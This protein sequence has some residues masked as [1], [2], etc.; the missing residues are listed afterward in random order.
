MEAEGQSKEDI[1]N[2]F[3]LARFAPIYQSVLAITN[4]NNFITNAY[5]SKRISELPQDYQNGVKMVNGLVSK[6]PG[7]I[8]KLK[9]TSKSIK[10]S[11]EKEIVQAVIN[12]LDG[13]R[14]ISTRISL[15]KKHISEVN[16]YTNFIIKCTE[17]FRKYNDYLINDR[18]LR[19]EVPQQELLDISMHINDR[20]Q[21]ILVLIDEL[22]QINSKNNEHNLYS[23]DC[24][25]QFGDILD[26]IF[27]YVTLIIKKYE[28]VRY[29]IDELKLRVYGFKP[30]TSSIIDRISIDDDHK[31]HIAEK[32]KNVEFLLRKQ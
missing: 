4:L 19:I 8:Q 25:A 28:E 27:A 2:E 32:L 22:Y 17:G 30:P 3:E 7:S 12:R 16:E 10:E 14:Y 1:E 29:A 18:L 24:L 9:E 5:F 23:N 20:I 11:V 21:Q 13:I 6:V 26:S 15:V 31:N